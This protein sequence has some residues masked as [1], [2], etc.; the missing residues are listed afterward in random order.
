MLGVFLFF[1]LKR[2]I[3]K[4]IS[5]I[6]SCGIESYRF[7]SQAYHTGGVRLEHTSHL[8]G[9]FY[10]GLDI[11]YGKYTANIMAVDYAK[12]TILSNEYFLWLNKINQSIRKIYAM[13]MSIWLA[14]RTYDMS[15][16]LSLD[17]GVGVRGA[18]LLIGMPRAKPSKT[19][20]CVSVLVPW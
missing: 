4:R 8:L 11:V 10:T 1:Y 7:C 12:T 20:P 19:K 17:M 13:I 15:A 16:T 18:A 14:S 5:I 3:K 2:V 9:L 6:N